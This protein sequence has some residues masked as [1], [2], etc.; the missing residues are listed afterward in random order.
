MRGTSAA[1]SSP[2]LRRRLRDGRDLWLEG[3]RQGHGYRLYCPCDRES[4]G[5]GI[6]IPGTPANPGNAPKRLRRNL[7][8]CPDSHELMK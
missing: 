8:H 5:R 1:A 6:P 4:G 3:A 7:E 2:D